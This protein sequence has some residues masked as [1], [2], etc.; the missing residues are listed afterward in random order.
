MVQYKGILD[1]FYEFDKSSDKPDSFLRKPARQSFGVTI[2]SPVIEKHKKIELQDGDILTIFTNTDIIFW[3]GGIQKAD[4]SK[5]LKN[6]VSDR[7]TRWIS[8][9]WFQ[10]DFNPVEWYGLVLAHPFVELNTNRKV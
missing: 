2:N 7:N 4:Y 1:L 5:F 6:L 9:E 3:Q 8:M 10:A